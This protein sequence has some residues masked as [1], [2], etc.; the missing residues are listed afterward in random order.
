MS[1]MPRQSSQADVPPIARTILFW[2]LLI[3]LAAVLW[4]F[5]SEPAPAA[6]RFLAIF[7]L[8][9]AAPI[10][11]AVASLLWRKLGHGRAGS[12]PGPTNRPIG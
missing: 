3:G 4:K 5:A 6:L 9:L 12:P 7:L 2:A 11:L 1:I 8:V 10:V